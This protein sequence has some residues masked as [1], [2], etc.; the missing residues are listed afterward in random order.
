MTDHR[1]ADEF[2]DP[3][4]I[5]D[6]TTLVSRAAAAILAIDPGDAAARAKPDHSPVTA[7]DEAA[8]AVL[9]AGLGRLLPGIPVVSEESRSGPAGALDECFVLVDPLDGTREYLAGRGEYTVNVAIVVH[10]TPVVGLVATPPLGLVWRGIV[11]QGTQRLVL[12]PGAGPADAREIRPIRTRPWSDDAVVVAVSRSHLDPATDA[13]V[14]RLPRC[15][16][17]VSGSSVKFTR[18]AEGEVDL[19]PRLAPVSEWDIAAGHAV[20]CAAGGA[21]TAPDGSRLRYG[22]AAAGFLVPG[23]VACGDP[24]ALPH[25]VAPPRPAA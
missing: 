20:L 17:V 8:D 18:I 4:L 16:R 23:F 24:A 19:Y 7:A 22:R 15:R 14:A 13:F 25:L 9:V 1:T 3:T 6:L 2:R 11:G 12:A 21:V 10:G 5:D